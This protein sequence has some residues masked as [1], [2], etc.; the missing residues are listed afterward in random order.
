[1]NKSEQVTRQEFD[2]LSGLVQKI[3]MAITG[4]PQPIIDGTENLNR[5]LKQLER[6]VEALTA[7]LTE[8]P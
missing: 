1:M 3:G 8:K 4:E 6:Q 5:R 7:R 2:R